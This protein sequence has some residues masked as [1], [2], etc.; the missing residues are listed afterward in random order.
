MAKGQQR[1]A[2]AGA[3]GGCSFHTGAILHHQLAFLEIALKFSSG[4]D[5]G[6]HALAFSCDVGPSFKLIIPLTIDRHKHG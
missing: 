3:Q 1:A 6:I 2:C 5:E 4:N